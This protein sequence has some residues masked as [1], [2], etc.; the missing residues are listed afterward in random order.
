MIVECIRNVYHDEVCICELNSGV[1]FKDVYMGKS[2]GI[3]EELLKRKV[4]FMNV[5]PD[6]ALDICVR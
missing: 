4:I 2:G 5:R 6:N 1:K 3:P